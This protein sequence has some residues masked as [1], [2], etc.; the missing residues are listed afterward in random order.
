M[1]IFSPEKRQ[2]LYI[3]LALSGMTMLLLGV[4]IGLALSAPNN[5]RKNDDEGLALS[6]KATP[7][8]T[9]QDS[10]GKANEEEKLIIPSAAQVVLISEFTSC[11]HLA[12]REIDMLGADGEALTRDISAYEILE[13]TEKRAVLR[14]SREGY[15]PAHYLLVRENGGLYVEKRS[16]ADGENEQVMK[17]DFDAQNISEELEAEINAGIAFDTLSQIDEFIENIES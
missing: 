5:G 2:K 3:V 12:E 4:F 1:D 9:V 6:A 8:Q 17:L 15:C 13:L 10:N 14:K 7:S 11:G 16:E